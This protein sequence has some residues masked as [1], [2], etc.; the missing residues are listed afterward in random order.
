MEMPKNVSFWGGATGLA[1]AVLL[2]CTA[3]CIPVIGPVL[4]WFLVGAL[5]LANPFGLAI[6]ALLAAAIVTVTVKRRRRRAL[7]KSARTPDGACQGGC[8][9][10]DAPGAGSGD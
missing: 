1:G 8:N 2:A 5:A 9:R 7:C 3:C 4:A 6:A 10:G